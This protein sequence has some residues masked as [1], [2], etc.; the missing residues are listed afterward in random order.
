[1]VKTLSQMINLKATLW[2][3]AFL[4]YFRRIWLIGK[5]IPE[6]AYANYDL[7]KGL[8]I[9]AVI[10]RQC[11][12]FFGKPLY[13]LSFIGLPLVM[14]GI[15]SRP[16]L[17]ERAFS[18][19]VQVLFFLN[20]V[21]GS[22]GDSQIFTVTRDKVTCIKY[23]HMN[24]RTYLQSALAFKYIPFFL[25]YL[26][27]LLL[28]AKLLG[29][30]L[31][32][33]FLL[34]V[35][36]ISFRMIGEALQLFIFDRKGKVIS[37]NMVYEWILIGIGFT[38]AYLP[39]MLG[40]QFSLDR[41]LLHPAGVAVYGALGGICLWY[42]TAGYRGYEEKFHR[43][44]DLNFLFSSILKS[45][46]GSSAAFK[47]VE[48]KEGDAEVSQAEEHKFK[49]LKGYAYINALFFARH[50]RQLVKPVYYRFIMVAVMFAAAMILLFTD[51]ELA[52]KLAGNMTAVLP[53]FVYIM[54]FM[55]IADKASRAMFYNCD[56]DM[57]RYAYY[58]QPQTILKNF[59]I[60]LL[61]V[62]LYDIVIAGA[63][64]LAA[65]IFAALCG[66]GIVTVDMLLFCV[67]ILLLSILFT[68]HH[69]CLYYIFQ[70]YSESL[71]VKNPFFS[72]INVG[73]YVLCFM[74][75]QIETGGVA[76][77][78]GLLVFTVFYIILALILV[79]RLSPKSFRVK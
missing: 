45:S 79:Y 34:W 2:V 22:F 44:I 10:F 1:M 19:M 31:L 21:I 5:W 70:P 78:M 20:C 46:S 63:V 60:R 36:L 71:Q 39:A 33:G 29:K 40:W 11:M 15:G 37:R 23:L 32:Q 18:F 7:K 12:D 26:P 58:R 68:A 9:A 55:T 72:F 77:T 75:L 30:T 24:A 50:K 66:V 57:L 41:I 49:N 47:E 53:F 8:S 56:K 69:L 64:C 48:I 73:M 38:G 42:I 13:L 74:C 54:Y 17:G 59:K 14:M 67:A 52:I 27:W 16:E 76:F 61:R 28:A 62:S 4:Y 35:M 25:Y 6:S 51:R 43:S 65:M 3:N